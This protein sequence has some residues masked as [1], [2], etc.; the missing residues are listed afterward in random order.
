M[1]EPLV[2]PGS[3]DRDE[4]CVVDVTVRPT[5]VVQVSLYIADARKMPQVGLQMRGSIVKPCSV[6]NTDTPMFWS[7]WTLGHSCLHGGGASPIAQMTRSLLSLHP[8]ILIFAC[9]LEP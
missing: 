4:L 5:Q 9:T 8:G 7:C 2:V 3:E 6:R 1:H